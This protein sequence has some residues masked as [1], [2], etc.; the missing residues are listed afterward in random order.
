MNVL[1]AVENGVSLCTFNGI[2]YPIA[3]VNENVIIACHNKKTANNIS[4]RTGGDVVETPDSEFSYEVKIKVELFD[5]IIHAD[6][7][8]EIIDKYIINK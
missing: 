4:L 8:F 3:K 6:S 2:A 5:K 1:I 7:W